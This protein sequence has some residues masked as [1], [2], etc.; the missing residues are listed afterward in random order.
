MSPETAR[1]E[2]ISATRILTQRPRQ[3]GPEQC[4][5]CLNSVPRQ[6]QMAAAVSRCFSELSEDGN[7][8][9]VRKK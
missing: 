4:S 6:K 1:T 5:A 3:S 7:N 2:S 9:P 8:K